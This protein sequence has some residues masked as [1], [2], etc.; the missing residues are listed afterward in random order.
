MLED[1]TIR[2]E[3]PFTSWRDPDDPYRLMVEALAEAAM[4]GAASPLPIADSIANLR[5]IELI[6]TAAHLAG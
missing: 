6:R 4:T 3:Q 5:V 2:I 1:R